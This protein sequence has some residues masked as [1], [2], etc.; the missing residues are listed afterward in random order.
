VAGYFQHLISLAETV[1]EL[2]YIFPCQ[3]FHISLISCSN[4]PQLLHENLKNKPFGKG[5]CETAAT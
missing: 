3:P 1:K 4:T 2:T 5:K